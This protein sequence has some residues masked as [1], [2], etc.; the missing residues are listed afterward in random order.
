MTF[1][2][3]HGKFF[4]KTLNISTGVSKLD[5]TSCKVQVLQDLKQKIYLKGHA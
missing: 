3:I 2:N 4:L 5:K 1:P